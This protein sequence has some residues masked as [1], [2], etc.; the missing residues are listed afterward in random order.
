VA[1]AAAA[2]PVGV[3]A[4]GVAAGEEGS[5][6]RAGSAESGGMGRA[7]SLTDDDMEELKGCVDLGFGLTAGCWRLPLDCLTASMPAVHGGL[8]RCLLLSR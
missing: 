3:C 8:P 1:R 4:A 2:G 5:L 7:R 6:A